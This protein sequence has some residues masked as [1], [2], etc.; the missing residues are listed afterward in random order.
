M[1]NKKLGFVPIYRSLQEHWIWKYKEPFDHRSAWIDL[2]LMVNHKEDKLP[3]GA[4]VIT[5]KPGQRWLSY[6]Q[7]GQRWG[8]S[9]RK[10]LRFIAQLKSDHMVQTDGTPNGTLLTVINWDNFNGGGKKH[11]T[12][13]G[14]TE[15]TTEGSTPVITGDTTDG[16]QTIMN[17]KDNNEEEVKKEKRPPSPGDGYI[18][19]DDLNRWIAP[20]TNGG[21]YQ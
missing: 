13:D 1:A 10:V 7:L 8:W 3:V 19:N 14:T 16:I 20:P 4:N 9:Y 11:D 6:Q 2:L 17:N 5:I 21:N 12:T 15:G 18:W